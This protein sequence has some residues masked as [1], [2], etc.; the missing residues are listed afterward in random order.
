MRKIR[1][2]TIKMLPFVSGILNGSGRCC[3]NGY[4]NEVLWDEVDVRRLLMLWRQF[5]RCKWNL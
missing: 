3:R 1:S 2:I 5:F 4:A